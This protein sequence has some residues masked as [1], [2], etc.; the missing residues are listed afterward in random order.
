[1]ADALIGLDPATR[2]EVL[3]FM[4]HLHMN[5]RDKVR[6]R[7]RVTYYG[8]K[9]VYVHDGLHVD[10]DVVDVRIDDTN[11]VELEVLEDHERVLT[12][13]FTMD[14]EGIEDVVGIVRRIIT[15]PGVD[16]RF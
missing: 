12:D 3:G 16:H 9:I 2:N 10:I 1:M 6:P 4:W 14:L 7:R 13:S 5:L 11:W 8:D 15:E